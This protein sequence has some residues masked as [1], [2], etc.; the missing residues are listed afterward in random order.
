MFRRILAVVALAAASVAAV[1]PASAA[2]PA[3]APAAAQV[4]TWTASDDITKYTSFP[5]TAVAGAATIVFETSIATGN[6]TGMSHTVTF[7]TSTPGYNHDVNLNIVANPFDAQNGRHEQAVTLTPGKYRYFCAMPGHSMMVGEI[8]VGP[9]GPDTTPPTVSANV[10]GTKN[11]NGEYVGKATVTVNAQDAESGVDK[12]EYQVDDTSFLPYTGPFDVT[13]IGDHSVQYRATDKAGNTSPVG[14]VQFKV[15]VANPDTTPPTVNSTVTGTKDTSGNYIGKATVTITAT[16]SGS[17][18]KTVEYSMDGGAFTGYTAPFDVT[19]NGSHMVHY[20]ATDNANNVSP[21][22]MASFTVVAPPDTTPPTVNAAVTGTKDT[23]G[24]YVGQATVTITATDSGSGVKKIEYILDSGVYTA[25]TSPV[26]VGTTGTH[27][28]KFRATDNANNVSPEG[29]T[30]F[31]VVAP[32]DT[33]PP[34]VTHTVTGTK[35][36]SGNYIGKA[37]VTLTATDAGSGVRS[38]EYKLDSGA[39]AAYPAPVDVTTAGAHMFHYRATDNAGNVSPEGMASFTVVIQDTTPPTVNAS[40]AGTKDGNGNYVGQATVTI[41]A[42]DSGSG[43][44]KIEYILD[45]GVYTPYTSPVVVTAT[46]VHTFKYRATD[47]AG[48]VAPETTTSFTIVA[49][50][51]T[52]PPTTTAVVSGNK[53]GNGNYIDTATVTVTATDS[54]SG[55]NKIEYAL[56]GGAWTTYPGAVRVGAQGAHTLK[57]RATDNAG[58]VSPE[59]SVT[60]TVVPQGSDA[61]PNSDTRATVRIGGEDT[62]IANVDTGNGCTINDL[63]AEHAQYPGH[64]VFVRHVETVTDPLVANGVLTIRQQGTI[65]RAASRSDIG[66]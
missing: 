47:N 26:V 20:R 64:G 8:T 44:Q 63:I 57:Y 7:D 51:D 36:T 28:V 31:T 52:T 40:V 54:Q 10:T 15:V 12:V 55:V 22:G 32:P 2:T 3:A 66:R 61:C 49:V 21:E 33:T 43:V 50:P 60:F 9:G 1:I 45:N 17:G 5:T 38:V 53:D 25:Y 65:V 42:T 62:G 27:T 11:T 24:N 58:N 39:F 19:A 46:G 56:D 23:S 6:T 13:A 18:V 14:S 41:T 48:N 34:T 30:S 29:T 16:D 59:Q 37:T 35:D 4:L